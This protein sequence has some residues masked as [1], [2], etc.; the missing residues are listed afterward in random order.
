MHAIPADG[1]RVAARLRFTLATAFLVSDP[2]STT[3]YEPR[4]SICAAKTEFARCGQGRAPL[5]VLPTVKAGATL[6]P[7]RRDV[8][9]LP[10]QVAS[11][12]DD[13]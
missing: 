13:A 8:A 10:A 7:P 11:E 2:D 1:P 3:D 5:Y 6:I 12:I 4:A 9:Q